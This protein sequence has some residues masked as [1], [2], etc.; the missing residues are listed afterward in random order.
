MSDTK[1]IYV[2][3]RNFH[4]AEQLMWPVYFH[5]ET[6]A[7]GIGVAAFESQAKETFGEEDVRLLMSQLSVI[8]LRHVS[9][10]S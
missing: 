7:R 9:D 6:V 1:P 2:I 10:P 5:S 8:Q 3:V 4:G